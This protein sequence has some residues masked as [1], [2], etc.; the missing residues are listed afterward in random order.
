MEIP[1]FTK[2]KAKTLK[3]KFRKAQNNQEH[4]IKRFTQQAFQ[5]IKRKKECNPI[6]ETE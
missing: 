4:T 5:K 6:K 3:Q 2:T 1:L